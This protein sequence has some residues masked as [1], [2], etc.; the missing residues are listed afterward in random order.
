MGYSTRIV[1]YHLACYL[2][3]C[4]YSQYLQF[5]SQ[6]MDLKIPLLVRNDQY[7]KH[8]LDLRIW[9]RY[10]IFNFRILLYIIS[11][12]DFCSIFMDFI[13]RSSIIKEKIYNRSLQ[14]KRIC[15]LSRL[16]HSCD[17]YQLWHGYCLFMGC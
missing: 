6:F 9:Q 15:P 11:P 17:K 3:R 8:L 5:N 2:F 4:S 7:L 16:G 13:R 14:S 10:S 1:F 12:Y